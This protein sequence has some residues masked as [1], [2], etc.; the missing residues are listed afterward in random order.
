MMRY[1][2][3]L[4]QED[5]IEVAT[6]IEQRLTDD[7]DQTIDTIPYLLSRPLPIDLPTLTAKLSNIEHRLVLAHWNR[8]PEKAEAAYR[9]GLFR[10]RRM[11]GSG[12]GTM[13]NRSSQDTG[14]CAIRTRT[15]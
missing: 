3:S 6:N 1:L 11:D 5:R 13:A 12:S 14:F 2:D 15:T 7:E 8:Y 4:L 10:C 9:Q